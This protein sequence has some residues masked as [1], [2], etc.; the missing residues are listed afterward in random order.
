[1][2]RSDI[3]GYGLVAAGAVMILSGFSAKNEFPVRNDATSQGSDGS[4]VSYC[5]LYTSDAA[6]EEDSVDLGGRRTIKKK[7]DATKV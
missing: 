3:L 2:N 7:K 1:M 4:Q 5:L 6:D